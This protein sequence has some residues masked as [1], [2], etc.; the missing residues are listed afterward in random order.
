MLHYQ[1]AVKKFTADVDNDLQLLELMWEEWKAAGDPHD[2]LKVTITSCSLC[3]FLS[4][5]HDYVAGLKRCY[6]LLF[7]C[8]YPDSH[9]CDS[10][11]GCHQQGICHGRSEQYQV[12]STN[13]CKSFGCQEDTELVLLAHRWFR[14]LSHCH[15]WALLILVLIYWQTHCLST[16]SCSQI[17]LFWASKVGMCL[18][19]WH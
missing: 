18:D 11:H 15:R 1:V 19:W 4:S 13:S 5:H 17:G 12:F 8:R 16:A 3:S 7:A 6:T 10:S 2:I 9:H 14:H